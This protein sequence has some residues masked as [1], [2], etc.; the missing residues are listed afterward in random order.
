MNKCKKKKTQRERGT[1]W[2]PKKNSKNG[3][4]RREGGTG[5]R[6]G[7]FEEKV[8]GWEEE[9]L[10]HKGKGGKQP[11]QGLKKTRKRYGLRKMRQNFRGGPSRQSEC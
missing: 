7:A 2:S 4:R 10:P 5:K 3:V 9:N 1:V 6:Q 11:E 8:R